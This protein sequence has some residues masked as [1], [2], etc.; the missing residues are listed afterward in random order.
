MKKLLIIPSDA[1][2]NEMSRSYYF[3]KYLSKYYQVYQVRWHDVQSLS[4]ENRN[5]SKLKTFYYW[6]KSIFTFIRIENHPKE[7][8]KWI[9][10]PFMSHMIIYRIMGMDKASVL[11]RWFNKISLTKICRKIKP[12]IIFYADGFERFPYLENKGITISDV[13][14]DID[15][16]NFSYTLYHKQYG[17]ENFSKTKKNYIVS[18]AAATRLGKYYDTEFHYLPNGAD[19]DEMRAINVQKLDKIKN[20]LGL[21]NKFVV[22]FIGGSVWFDPQ[23]AD[24]LFKMALQKDPSIHFIIVGNVTS[25]SEPLPNVTFIGAVDNKESYY[26]YHLSEIGLLL[27]PSENSPFL[28]N[29]MPLKI[30]Q[31]SCLNKS[32][33]SPLIAW[34][35]DE[36]YSNVKIIKDFSAPLLLETIEDIKNN[37]ISEDPRWSEYDWKKIVQNIINDI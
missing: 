7:N 19:F 28:Y 37:G 33:I 29:S 23:L 30:I 4:F 15:E 32:I 6:L 2:R 3:A 14:D 34:L 35:E 17:K 27:K 36:N 18:K 31:Y 9:W 12:D 24:L 13:Q 25:I 26:Y 8:Y 16:S 22:S 5:N 1:I 11:S 10:I 21:Q 20:S